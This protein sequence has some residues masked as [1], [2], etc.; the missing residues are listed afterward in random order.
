MTCVEPAILFFD[1]FTTRIITSHEYI[2]FCIISQLTII[3]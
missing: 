1:L 3:I 2:T